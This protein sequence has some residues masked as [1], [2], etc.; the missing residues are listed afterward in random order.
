MSTLTSIP[1][2]LLLQILS[3]LPSSIHFLP[4]SQ[5]NSYLRSFFSTHASTICNT[6]IT[7]YHA[8][9][10][11]ILLPIHHSSGWLVPTHP[12]VLAEERRIMRDAILLSGC[13]CYDCRL[14][15]LSSRTASGSGSSLT[16]S[17]M[18]L[19]QGGLFNCIPRTPISP[20]QCKAYAELSTAVKLTSPGPQFLVFLEKYG[21]DIEIRD[22]MRSKQQ[23]YKSTSTSLEPGHITQEEKERSRFDFMV[24]NFS[25]RR[26]LE[27]TERELLSFETYLTEAARSGEIQKCEQHPSKSG[28]RNIRQKIFNG[29]QCFGR[30]STYR[31]IEGEGVLEP[32]PVIPKRPLMFGEIEKAGLDFEDGMR[33]R[34]ESW[35]KGLL[36]YHTPDEYDATNP[37]PRNTPTQP[38]KASL[39]S[40]QWN[41]HH[42]LTH[43]QQQYNKLNQRLQETKSKVRETSK[44]MRSSLGQVLQKM[45]CGVGFQSLGD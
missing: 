2:E 29:W 14:F 12:C 40:L 20:S 26:F 15:L 4:L 21:R 25:V 35:V 16:L 28:W 10:A 33:S 32:K 43:P 31:E 6:H 11:A 45:R 36:W 3:H 9:P 8:V 27:D 23:R 19:S 41:T 5:T 24:G 37:V 7:T 42:P 38:Q 44:K 34:R 18:S 17:E 1:P 39:P 22:S 30:K 13:G